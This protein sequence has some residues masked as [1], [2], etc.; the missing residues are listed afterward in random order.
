LLAWIAMVPLALALRGANPRQGFLLGGAFAFTGWLSSIWWVQAPLRD[1]LKLSP[2]VAWVLLMAGCAVSSLPYAISGWLVA[3]APSKDGIQSCVQNAAI[4]TVATSW[5]PLVFEGNIAH[6]QYQYP[7]LLQLLDF[8]GTPL[9]LFLI[10]WMNWLALEIFET[11][12]NDSKAVW[13]PA[14]MWMLTLTL[15]LI[16]GA[17][18]ISDLDNE[19][20]VAPA[21]SLFTVGAIQPN[22]PILVAPDKQPSSSSEWTNDFLST[23]GQA[24]ALVKAHPEID[25]L[26]FPENPELFVINGDQPKRQRLAEMI[27]RVR[28]P[29]ILNA[30]L[31]DRKIKFGDYPGRYNIN[32]FVN[33]AAV[34][35]NSYRKMKLVPFIEYLPLENR[36]P[37][38]RKFFPRSLGVL[39]GEKPV[40]FDVKTNVR[41]IPLI[42]FEG[43]SASLARRFVEDGG[44]IILNLV[45][46]GWFLRTPA[47]EVHL[48]LGL[49]RAIELRAPMV[50]VTNSGI[51]AFIQPTGEII[52]GTRTKLYEKAATAGT[53]YIPAQR[54]FYA[55]QGDLLLVVLTAC[56]AWVFRH[57]WKIVSTIFA[58]NK[59]SVVKE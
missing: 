18:R 20:K 2:G 58:R 52:P 44:N 27:S 15:V 51:G 35:T 33:D 26:A 7:L 38:L 21:E 28:K 49:F 9:L 37:A 50:R 8:G 13:K 29:V 1:I 48:A 34:I 25:L 14:S 6:S 45:N 4:F 31:F 19:I 12:R 23:L 41:V 53:V 5:F 47:S 22:I 42:C 32:V 17:F 56:L 57:Q 24:E 3:V 59:P 43:T 39:P 16:Y 30:T 54:S 36:F 10:Y 55:Q 46:D 40:L 11:L